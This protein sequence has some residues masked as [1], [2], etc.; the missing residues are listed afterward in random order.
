[1]PKLRSEEHALGWVVEALTGEP[2]YL[3]KPM[4]GCLA[5][6]LHGCLVLVLADRDEPFSG[7][8]VPT[9]RQW[10]ESIKEE[11]PALGGHPILGKWL[12]LSQSDEEFE[13]IA[14]D[15]V[16]QILNSDPR[17]GIEP[18]GGLGRGK[19]R[20]KLK[21]KSGRAAKAP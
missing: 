21:A 19:S 18:K 12:Y 6:Y 16:A 8:L 20:R 1:M 17:F 13:A 2:D 10:H 9:E 11:F 3:E 4:F 15:V 14:Q 7:M 5:S